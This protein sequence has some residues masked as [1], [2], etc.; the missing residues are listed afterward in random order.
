MNHAL[1]DL[2]EIIFHPGLRKLTARALE[3]APAAFWQAPASTSGKYHKEDECAPGGLVLHTRRVFRM[4]QHLCDMYGIRENALLRS[5]VL[6]AALL[7]DTHKVLAAGEHS[8]FDHPIRAARTVAHLL[9]QYPSIPPHAGAQL[10]AAIESHMGRW[11][12]STRCPDVR[13]PYPEG[14]HCWILHTADYLASRK[15]VEISEA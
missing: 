12:T 13:L 4:A 3:A 2:I 6:A 5:V 8:V 11:T 10:L 9:E 7:H 14:E 1:T 15:N